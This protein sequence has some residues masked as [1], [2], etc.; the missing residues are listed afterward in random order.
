MITYMYY[1]YGIFYF[2][3]PLRVSI[4]LVLFVCSIFYLIVLLSHT[5]TKWGLYLNV[6]PSQNKGWMNEFD[7]DK[8]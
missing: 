8:N 3:L 2:L 1:Y 5:D 6:F 4:S 7:Y